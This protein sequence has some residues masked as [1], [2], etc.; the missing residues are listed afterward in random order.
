MRSCTTLSGCLASHWPQAG[1]SK[2]SRAHRAPTSPTLC[3]RLCCFPPLNP[4]PLH[5]A[6]VVTSQCLPLAPRHSE[7]CTRRAGAGPGGSSGREALRRGE[8]PGL[9]RGSSP[10]LG[11][12]SHSF[13]LQNRA[14]ARPPACLGS[15]DQGKQQL[16]VTPAPRCPRFSSSLTLA[17]E[18]QLSSRVTTASFCTLC[19]TGF[20]HAGKH[21]G[22][23]K[24]Q[25]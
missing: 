11:T 10:A 2:G 17:A 25:L 24:N 14:V 12:W 22:V 4:V 7:R 23:I 15:A 3:P 13:A 20:L 5:V 9:S 18:L 16:V 6:T 8:A 19:N 21:G 1:A